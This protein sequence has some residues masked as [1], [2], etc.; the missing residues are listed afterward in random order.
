MQSR[1]SV[2]NSIRKIVSSIIRY[3]HSFKLLSR[4]NYHGFIKLPV[5]MK[6]QGNLENDN[7]Q[8]KVWNDVV[9]DDVKRIHSPIPQHVWHLKCEWIHLF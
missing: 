8:D 2:Q 5:N 6:N 1:E 7:Y 9:E 3:L 4:K